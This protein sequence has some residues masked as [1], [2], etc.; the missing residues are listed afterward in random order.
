VALPGVYA[1]TLRVDGQVYRRTVTVLP[2][3][4][5]PASAADL[6]AQHA[7]QMDLMDGLRSAWHGYEQ[8]AALRENIGDLS[9][10]GT[11]AEL[12]SAGSLFG[13]RLDSIGG[14]DIQRGGRGRPGMSPPPTFR[15]VSNA[16][17]SQLNAQDNGDMA[18]TPAM[19]AAYRKSCD[20]L[21]A[22]VTRW[23]AALQR[24]LGD[25]NAVRRR[26]GLGDLAAPSPTVTMPRC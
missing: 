3:P 18:P 11:A 14:L 4:R 16:L 24:D 22:V 2:D 12:V 15:G 5:S 7:L 17:V 20:E 25:F 10:A 26:N 8:V 9:R 19:L 6:R 23:R 1:L 21:R 13:A